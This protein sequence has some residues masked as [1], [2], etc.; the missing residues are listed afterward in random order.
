M[1]F[2]ADELSF[3]MSNSGEFSLWGGRIA[4]VS[5]DGQPDAAPVNYEFDGQHFYIGGAH[6]E[7]TR[8]YENIVAGNTKVAFVVDDVT[9]AFPTNVRWLRIYGVAEIVEREVFGEAQLGGQG[10]ARCIKITPATSWSF[11]MEARGFLSK[12]WAL[13]DLN[14]RPYIRTVHAGAQSTPAPQTRVS[15]ATPKTAPTHGPSDG[16]SFDVDEIGYLKA[17]A[18]FF[19]RFPRHIATVSSDGQPDVV[20]V[21]YE[22]DGK[23]VYVGGTRNE[24]TRKYKNV[25]AGN[26][27]AA[28]LVDDR[29]S[30]YPRNPRWVRI[31][32]AAEILERHPFYR[33][34]GPSSWIKITPAISWSFNLEGRGFMPSEDRMLSDPNNQRQR[35]VIHTDGPASKA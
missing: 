4:T 5:P 18:G 23:H 20:P 14:N 7:A 34:H 26:T 12:D 8:E 24:T 1:S 6:V 17:S 22:F 10:S 21:G 31:H 16:A 35:C 32:G 13:I 11:N 15:N 28:F 29:S 33:G 2:N 3:L 30:V 19:S 9:Q 25:K 27:K